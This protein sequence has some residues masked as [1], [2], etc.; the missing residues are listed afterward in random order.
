MAIKQ[1]ILASESLNAKG[2]VVTLIQALVEVGEKPL[3]C[4]EWTL[5][6]QL[7]QP[8]FLT[9]LVVLRLPLSLLLHRRNKVVE[10]IRVLLYTCKRLLDMLSLAK[11]DQRI[12]QK[13]GQ[14]ATK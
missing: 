10:K 12:S 13:K 3:A 1:P 5:R 2:H 7:V 8:P 14:L 6:V 11:I 4:L 9:I